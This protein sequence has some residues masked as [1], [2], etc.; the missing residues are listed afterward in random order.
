MASWI[1]IPAFQLFASWVARLMVVVRWQNMQA[2]VTCVVVVV[3]MCVSL[4]PRFFAVK[5]VSSPSDRR[6]LRN[7]EG[8]RRREVRRG[9]RER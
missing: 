5:A 7:P 9:I 4:S 3:S 2:S 1:G 8:A 6:A